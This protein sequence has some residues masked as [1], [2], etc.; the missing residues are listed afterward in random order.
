[1]MGAQKETN[2]TQAKG[3]STTAYILGRLF[4]LFALGLG[5]ALGSGLGLPSACPL[6]RSG[7]WES[8][9]CYETTK[10]AQKQCIP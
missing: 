3:K 6:W 10:I 9:N 8:E 7:A 1:M 2:N 5:L 4:C